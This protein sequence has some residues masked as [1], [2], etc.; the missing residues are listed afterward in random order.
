VE[1]IEDPIY[2]ISSFECNS[3]SVTFDRVDLS[4]EANDTWI[5][6]REEASISWSGTYAYDS[7]P[8]TGDVRLN[9]NKLSSKEARRGSSDLGGV[10]DS[11]TASRSLL[12]EH[13]GGGLGQDGFR[14]LGGG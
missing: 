5:N 14:A 4:L 10:D 13:G 11:S 8:F 7:M 6:V 2:N 12:L 1:E 3:V 9:T